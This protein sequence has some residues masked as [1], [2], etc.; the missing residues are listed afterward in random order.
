MFQ[1]IPLLLPLPALPAQEPTPPP[2]DLVKVQASAPADF[3]RL[4][5]LGFDVDDH[6]GADANGNLTVYATA[7]EQGRLAAAGYPFFVEIYDLPGYYAARAA[8]APARPA[9]GP[10]GVVPP[11]S[12]GGQ[13]SGPPAAAA[14]PRL[15][16]P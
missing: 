7:A 11:P 12:E 6:A 13:D 2:Q 1:L 3:H 14:P 4:V 9:V 5:Q 10:S 16:A 8:A 15:S